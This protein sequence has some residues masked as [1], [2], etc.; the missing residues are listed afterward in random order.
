MISNKT[1]ERGYVFP[2]WLY[3]MNKTGNEEKRVNMDVVIIAKISAAIGYEASPE[4][5][6]ATD[7]ENRIADTDEPAGRAALGGTGQAR[8]D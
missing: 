6:F 8:R 5:I 4:D 2:L 3:E 1:E 7:E